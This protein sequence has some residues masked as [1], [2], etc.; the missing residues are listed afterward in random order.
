MLDQIRKY[1]LWDGNVPELGFLRTNYTDK[2]QS[3]TVS[4]PEIGVKVEPGP[5]SEGYVTNVEGILT[6][7]ED[8][9]EKALN[10]FDDD[11]S[12]ENGKKTLNEIKELKKGNGTATLIILDPFGQSNVVSDSVEIS[13]IPEEELNTLKT[14]FSHIEE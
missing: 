2:I 5:K 3:A 13:E 9:V 8:A 12:Q 7:F 14:G 6:R 4:I 11:A 1:N 10:L